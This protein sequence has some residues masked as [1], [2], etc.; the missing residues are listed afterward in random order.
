MYACT[1]AYIYIYLYTH[2]RVYVY[3]HIYTYTYTHTHTYTYTHT[4]I[5]TYIHTYIHFSAISEHDES[6]RS[7][8][9]ISLNLPYISPMALGPAACFHTTVGKLG[10]TS[11]GSTP[12]SSTP[13]LFQVIWGGSS[14]TNLARGHHAI[15]SRYDTA[16]NQQVRNVCRTRSPLLSPTGEHNTIHHTNKATLPPTPGPGR[17]QEPNKKFKVGK[18]SG[19]N[20]GKWQGTKMVVI[21]YTTSCSAFT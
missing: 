11:L 2:I 10:Q 5:H 3:I 15:L 17:A 12:T 19:G 14:T 8:D 20:I 6:F 13:N 1:R 7:I 4:Q 21:R 16:R 9:R 18:R